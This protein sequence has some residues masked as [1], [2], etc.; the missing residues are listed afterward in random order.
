MANFAVSEGFAKVQFNKV[1]VLADTAEEASKI[2]VERVERALD[3]ATK[4]LEMY[5]PGDGA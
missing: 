3:R 2:D 5:H 1:I 4:R